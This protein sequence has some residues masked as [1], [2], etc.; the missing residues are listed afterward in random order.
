[1]RS[2]EEEKTKSTVGSSSQVRGLL[3]RADGW[4]WLGQG[5]YTTGASAKPTRRREREKG[6]KSVER[7]VCLCSSLGGG[8]RASRRVL[9]LSCFAVPEGLFVSRT[10]R[11]Q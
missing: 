1:M 3:A 10:T 9:T 7:V 5:N 2:L 8:E 11:E 6:K 4:R